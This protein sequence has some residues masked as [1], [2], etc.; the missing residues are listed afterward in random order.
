MRRYL[1]QNVVDAAAARLAWIFD[2]FEH[3]SV[4]VSGGK[5]SQLLFELAYAEAQRRGRELEAFFLDQEAEYQA[6]VD[7]VR[8][9]MA[10]PGVDAHWYQVPIRMSSV[11]SPDQ[12]F[13]H[14][15][16]PGET[17]MRDREPGAIATIDGGYP[18]RFYP[19]IEWYERS[20]PAGTCFLV[21]LRA[22]ESLNRYRAVIRSPGTDGMLWTTRT[23]DIV[24]A[25]PI[26]DWS[27]DDIFTWFHHH[28]TRYN[29]IY[30]YLHYRDPRM[31]VTQY[32]VSNLVHERS[33][34]S[35]QFLQEF[36]PETY[37]RLQ[38]R[39]RGVRT[40]ARYAGDGITLETRRRPREYATWLEY[41]DHL[42]GGLPEEM[43]SAFRAR[44]ER[45]PENE[46]VHRQQVRQIVL[47]DFE[48]NLQTTI[49]RDEPPDWRQKW[50][51]LL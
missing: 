46:R 32:R 36:E 13:L 22:E 43:A 27:F 19:F 10:R 12:P 45:Q 4:S 30:D 25:Y 44:F 31:E 33:Y 39:L 47:N 26:Y 18:D 29:R 20:R 49:T 5:D 16:G 38:R 21:G 2:R 50:W 35:L 41:R 7:V 51:D 6:T 1:R 34:R 15:W 17:W 28:G 42:M 8:E 3:V 48:G 11:T 40:A 37:E 23:R 14:A 24:K 9:I